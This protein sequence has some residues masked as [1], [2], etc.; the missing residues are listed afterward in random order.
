[1]KFLRLSGLLLSSIMLLNSCL[2][3]QFD[4]PPDSS[5]QDPKL[6]VNCNISVLSNMAMMMT[7]GKT[8]LMGDTTI[9]GV[10]VGDDKGGNIYKK[11]FIQDST[12][13]MQLILD[14]TYL[15]GDY[16]VGRKIYVK[17]KGL[18]L[19]NYKGTPDIVFSMNDDGSTNGIPA[20]LLGTYLVK[21]NYPNSITP[22]QLTLFDVISNPGKYVN[23][24]VTIKDM[25]FETGSNN[26]VYSD[27]NNSTN[28]ALINCSKTGRITMYNSSYSNFQPAITPNGNG[29]ITGIITLFGSTAQL[30]L[31]D[32][33]DVRFTNPRCP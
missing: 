18:L 19:M 3:K 26:V 8:R 20:S 2:K 11:I 25:Q 28:R 29:T 31:R 1:M 16:P 23:T 17:L 13:G 33:T 12:G 27:P 9:Y 22:P 14:K 15:Y 32:T 4:A 5:Q 6:T 24:L 30:T 21:A 10:V 7:A